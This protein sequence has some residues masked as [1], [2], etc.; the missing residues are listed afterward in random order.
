MSFALLFTVIIF[1]SG[2]NQTT[3]FG[4]CTFVSKN[5]A[6]VVLCSSLYRN[7]SE[8][9]LDLISHW[10]VGNTIYDVMYLSADLSLTPR[11]NMTANSTALQWALTDWLG[12][13]S[14][15]DS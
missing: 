14:N 11:A 9:C 6:I 1:L 3:R 7:A 15:Q 10:E 2:F 13:N 5:L 4:N 12:N 8:R